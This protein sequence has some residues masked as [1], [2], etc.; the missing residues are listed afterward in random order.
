MA[1]PLRIE[2]PYAVSHITSQGNAGGE[3]YA[4]AD[5]G[6]GRAR[7]LLSYFSAC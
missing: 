7:C 2:Y 6:A 3:I 1:S 4:D 5:D